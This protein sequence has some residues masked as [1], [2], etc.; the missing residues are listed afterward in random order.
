MFRVLAPTVNYIIAS[1]SYTLY[2]AIIY[3]ACV[4]VCF[5]LCCSLLGSLHTYFCRVNV[6]LY[7]LSPLVMLMFFLFGVCVCCCTRLRLIALMACYVSLRRYISLSFRFHRELVVQY[8]YGEL[9]LV[10][11]SLWLVCSVANLYLPYLFKRLDLKLNVLTLFTWL[12]I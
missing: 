8:S 7:I 2:L 9:L 5:F 3:F 11:Y 12:S 6:P 4:Y 10:L 1:L